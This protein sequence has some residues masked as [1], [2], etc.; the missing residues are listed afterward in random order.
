MAL[1]KEAATWNSEYLPCSV[2]KGAPRASALTVGDLYMVYDPTYD[3][4]EDLKFIFRITNTTT[5]KC[6]KGNQG[7]CALQCAHSGS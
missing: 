2:F 6:E 7:T 4:S 3:I 1:I 5:T